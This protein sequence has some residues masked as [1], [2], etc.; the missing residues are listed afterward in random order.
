MKLGG[1][2]FEKAIFNGKKDK[3]FSEA[4][5]VVVK[6]AGQEALE[7]GIPQAYLESQLYQLNPDRDVVGNVV[8]NSVLGAIS[9]GGTS[10]SI[11]G[12]AATGDF[13]SNAIIAF[14]PNVQ[15]IIQTAP[16]LGVD[17]A[18]QQL[19]ELGLTD[20]TLQTN[21]L[22]Q[23]FDADFVGLQEKRIRV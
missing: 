6:E 7:E 19:A 23:A 17:A 22:N 12:G 21:I 15:N 5:D 8:G 14:N 1:N 20:T 10:G 18:Q 4:F 2:K 13:L 11:Y 9:G 3:N 16:D